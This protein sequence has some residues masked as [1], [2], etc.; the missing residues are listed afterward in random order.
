MLFSYKMLIWL[1][2]YRLVTTKLVEVMKDWN[3]CSQCSR[4]Q[5]KDTGSP[6]VAHIHKSKAR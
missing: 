2:I 3:W 6:L 1:D 4:P 5:V